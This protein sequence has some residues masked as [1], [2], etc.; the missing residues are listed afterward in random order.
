[1]HDNSCHLSGWVELVYGTV[2]VGKRNV[3]YCSNVLFL[4]SIKK[5]TGSTFNKKLSS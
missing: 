2:V 4:L 1:M 3:R 5:S